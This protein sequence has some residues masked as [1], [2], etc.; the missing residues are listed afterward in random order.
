MRINL[1]KL[2]R[3]INDIDN[4]EFLREKNKDNSVK[5]VFEGGE[6]KA[7]ERLNYYF[8]DKLHLLILYE[9]YFLL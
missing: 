2:N 4:I 8:Y 7:W 3:T 5:L 6:D 9:K 1:K